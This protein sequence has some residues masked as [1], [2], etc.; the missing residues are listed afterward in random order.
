MGTIAMP[1]LIIATKLVN[2]QPILPPFVAEDGGPQLHYDY[3][4]GI[5]RRGGWS[6]IGLPEK[7]KALVMVDAPDATILTMRGETEKYQVVTK[8]TEVAVCTAQKLPVEKY[9]ELIKTPWAADLEPV[10]AKE[11]G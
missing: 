11:I 9:R 6:L 3:V 4:K 7:G 10:A 2:G 8:E 1:K 5:P